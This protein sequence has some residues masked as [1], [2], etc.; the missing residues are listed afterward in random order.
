[1]PV[2]SSHDEHT[3]VGMISRAAL[4]RRYQGELGKIR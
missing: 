1:M 3:F 4:M 2:Q